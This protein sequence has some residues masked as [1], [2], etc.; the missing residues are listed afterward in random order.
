MA[1]PASV[2]ETIRAALILVGAISQ[3]E[4]PS[5]SEAQDALNR[6]I[7]MLDSWSTDQVDIYTVLRHVF[8]LGVSPTYTIG[9]GGVWNLPYAPMKIEDAYCQITSTSPLSE[10]PIDIVPEQVWA[11]IPVKLTTSPIPRKLWCDNNWPLSTI[12]L[13][14]VPTG[15]NNIVLYIWQPLTNITTLTSDIVLPP[16]YALAIIYNLAVVMAPFYGKT[17]SDDIKNLAVQTKMKIER[18]NLPEFILSCDE[19]VQSRPS[20]FNWLTGEP[21]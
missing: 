12:S 7:N 6:L 20:V 19:A 8:P 11:R 13:Y 18:R 2:Q 21:T 5:N 3:D 17:L 9:N 15:A 4:Q 1:D 14:P 16:G 10:I